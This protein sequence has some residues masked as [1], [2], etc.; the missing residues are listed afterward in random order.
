MFTVAHLMSF[1]VFLVVKVP[2]YTRSTKLFRYDNI[3]DVI[4]LLVTRKIERS[5]VTELDFNRMILISI[6][7]TSYS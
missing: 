2:S 4:R 7:M 3:I 5:T 1:G 6:K